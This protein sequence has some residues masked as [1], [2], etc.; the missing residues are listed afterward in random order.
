[1]IEERT[2]E[3][4]EALKTIKLVEGEPTKVTK[5]GTNLAISTRE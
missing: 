4:M 3:V 2:P 1:M 5:V